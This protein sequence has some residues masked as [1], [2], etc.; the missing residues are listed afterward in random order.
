MA[1]SGNVPEAEYFLYGTKALIESS[2]NQNFLTEHIALKEISHPGIQAD[3]GKP[4]EENG[5]ASFSFFEQATNDARDGKLEAVVTAP[6]SKLSWNLA[7]IPYAGHTEYL[8]SQFPGAIMT[9]FSSRLNL[10]LYS[11]HIP[12]KEAL[13]RIQK[14]DLIDFFL[15]LHRQI[16]ALPRDFRFLV[17]GLNPHAGESGVLGREE[18][19]EIVPAIE[20]ARSQG[21]P[22]S[23]PFPPDTVCRDA[24]DRPDRIVISLYHDQGL[25][26]FKLLAFNEGVNVT[27]G[28]PFIRTSPDHGTAFDIAGK[29]QADPGSMLQAIEFA[30]RFSLRIS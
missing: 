21:M 15:H 19:E 6:I 16:R 28:L 14:T 8:E 27:L 23:G 3:I 11:H 22:I 2:E 17:A 10:A 7:G 9:F 5:H 20:A 25:I 26:G 1:S 29:N 12:L 18:E 13:K 24:L 4:L 30:Y